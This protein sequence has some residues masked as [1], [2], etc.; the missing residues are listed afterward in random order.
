MAIAALGGMPLLL[1]GSAGR[2][3][4]PSV[5][6]L[7]N[8]TLDAAAEAIIMVGHVVTTDGASHTINTTGS[9]ALEWRSGTC[10]FT[11][12]STTVK[13]GLAAVDLTTGVPARA[14]NAANVITFDV[15]RTSIGNDGSITTAAWQ[16]HVPN[17]GTKTIANGD[18]VAFCVQMTARGATDSVLVSTVSGAIGV[19]LPTVTGYTGAAYA[20]TAGLPNVVITF[21]DG[22]RG[23]FFAGFVASIGAT[24]QSW[25]NISNPKEYGNFIKV[26]VPAK[27]YGIGCS[28]TLGGD[29]DLVMYSDPLGTP[30]AL[31]TI[32]IDKDTIGSASANMA[33]APFA[34][35]ISM[36]PGVAYAVIAK[37]SSATNISLPYLT[38]NSATHQE[39]YSLGTN[40]YAINRNTGAFVAQN[41]NKDRFA[42]GLMISGFEHGVAPVY[43]PGII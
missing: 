28:P 16:T 5:A 39:A 7:G 12:A 2:Q 15:A 40:A 10:V 34:T 8:T 21:A 33:Y 31:A 43:G 35:P 29:C 24:A 18:L 38:L 37:P 11:S 42:I 4:L 9:S 17:S 23:Y 3:N 6:A 13:I 26:P 30:A 41:A 22:A 32:S 25:N 14:V 19:S 1:V 27:A 20:T 36:T